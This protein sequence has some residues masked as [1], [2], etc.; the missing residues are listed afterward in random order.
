MRSSRKN[1][2]KILTFMKLAQGI[3]LALFVFIAVIIGIYLYSNL[4]SAGKKIFS[5]LPDVFRN[6]ASS[7]EPFFIPQTTPI[8]SKVL[9]PKIQAKAALSYDLTTNRLVYSKN[10]EDK[11]PIAS[12][13]KIMTALVALEEK[14]PNDKIVISKNAA[15]VGEDSMGL[16]R[17][18]KLTVKELLYGLFLHSGNDAA[19]ALAEGSTLGRENFIYRMNKKAEELGLSNTRFTNPSGLE[20]DGNQ[21]STALDLLVVAKHAVEKPIILEVAQTPYEFIPYNEDHKAYE[22][23][24]E[25]NLLTT[26]PGVK[27]LKTG[28]TPEAG[29]CLITYLEYKGHKIIGVILNSPSRRDE[30]IQILDYSLETLGVTP[31]NHG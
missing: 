21:Y 18:E 29:L 14:S 17:G 30:M 11:L 24:S 15:S 19:E 2:L 26:Y 10:I 6:F 3:L 27:G 5:P 9:K 13:T 4:G 22:L 23:Y 25:T 7:A 20:G 12:L 16:T 31:P 8:Q 28:Y 1:N